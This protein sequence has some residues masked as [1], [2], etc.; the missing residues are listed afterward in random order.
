MVAAHLVSQF[1]HAQGASRPNAHEK[2]EQG[3]VDRHAC[4]SQQNVVLPGTV[5]QAHQI[6][7]RGGQSV[8]IMCIL[9]PL[10]RPG[11]SLYVRV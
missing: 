6:E 3:A 4:L 8:A 2:R 1:N 10:H 7:Q 5:E 9:H 11:F